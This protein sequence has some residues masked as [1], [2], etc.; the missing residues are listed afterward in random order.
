MRGSPEL[1]TSDPRLELIES[2]SPVA[3]AEHPHNTGLHADFQGQ[4]NRVLQPGV[5]GVT[6]FF[7]AS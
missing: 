2:A 6:L 4:P 3:F 7:P 5:C 1:L